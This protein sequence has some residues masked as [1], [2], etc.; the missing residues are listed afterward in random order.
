M[1]GTLHTAQ[2]ESFIR[3]FKTTTVDDIETD[4]AAAEALGRLQV[5][6]DVEL[7]PRSR[8]RKA[9]G[10]K[11]TA[12]TRQRQRQQQQGTPKL[13]YMLLLQEIANRQR[14]CITID[15]DD[16]DAVSWLL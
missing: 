13:K 7:T 16:L 1:Y 15:L 14:D 11:Q 5:N 10:A 8:G 6:D 4:Q 3:D 2:F 12:A 9:R